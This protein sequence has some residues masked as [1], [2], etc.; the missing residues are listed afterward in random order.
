MTDWETL[1]RLCRHKNSDFK[2]G[3][4]SEGKRSSLKAEVGGLVFRQAK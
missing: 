4:G 1:K 3:E 2:I